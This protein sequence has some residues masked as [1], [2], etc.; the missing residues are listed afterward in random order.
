MCNRQM[1]Q[2]DT[3]N[4]VSLTMLTLFRI[5]NSVRLS[6]NSPDSLHNRR[7]QTAIWLKVNVRPTQCQPVCHHHRSRDSSSSLRQAIQFWLSKNSLRLVD[8]LRG[9]SPVFLRQ[10]ENW[11][12]ILQ[13]KVING[14]FLMN[15]FK[16]YLR[17]SIKNVTMNG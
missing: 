2:V 17:K 14:F 15:C 6:K 4:C 5:V 10:S 16:I 13:V 9:S 12:D 3:V 11:P 7:K 1:C 8:F